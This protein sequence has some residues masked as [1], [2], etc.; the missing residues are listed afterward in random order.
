MIRIWSFQAASAYSNASLYMPANTSVVLS[1]FKT[2]DF[3]RLIKN[4]GFQPNYDV[5]T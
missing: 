1:P 5:T 3:P 2:S 4:G